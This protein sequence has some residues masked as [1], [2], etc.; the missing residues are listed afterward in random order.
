MNSSHQYD[1]GYVTRFDFTKLNIYL[2]EHEI[3]HRILCKTAHIST[4]TLYRMLNNYDVYT[5]TI[6]N[7]LEALDILE[8]NKKHTPDDIYDYV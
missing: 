5:S 7:V 6:Q 4:E 8:P 3:P 1:R 2:I